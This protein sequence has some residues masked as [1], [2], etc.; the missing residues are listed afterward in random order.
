MPGADLNVSCSGVTR[1]WPDIVLIDMEMPVMN[2]VEAIAWMRKEE[3]RQ[4]RAPCVIVMLS[5][6]DDEHSIRKGMAAGCNRYLTKPVTREALLA[7]LHDLD[8]A[9]HSRPAAL[10]A[11]PAAGLGDPQPPVAASAP[12]QVE[13]SLRDEVP[14][15]LVSRHQIIDAMEA[16]LAAG[17]LAQLRELSH[18]ATGGLALFGFAW[19][20]WQGRRIEAGA[21]RGARLGLQEEIDR[22]RTH[23]R[24]V[25]VL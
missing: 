21:A 15:F 10:A 7:V 11:S 23:L 2:G 24:E 22:L 12:V 17:D 5:S 1:Q 16:A 4:R 8:V 6:N 18:K 14:D 25:R 19:A 20:A 3:K 13:P 9:G